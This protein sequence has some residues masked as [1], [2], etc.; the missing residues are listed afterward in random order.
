MRPP[1]VIKDIIEFLN[2]RF[3]RSNINEAVLRG[4][5]T[6]RRGELVEPESQTA[7]TPK[8]SVKRIL[9]KSGENLKS[10]RKM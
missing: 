4:S 7:M 10:G 1:N 2:S 9:T 5:L 8:C 6:D 3:S